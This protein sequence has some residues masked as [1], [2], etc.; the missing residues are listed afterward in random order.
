MPFVEVGDLSIHYEIAGRGEP[1]VLLHGM[2]NNSQSWRKQISELQ[3]HFTIIAWDAPGYGASSDPQYELRSF[4]QFADILKGFLEKL[5]YQSVNL[6]GHSMGAAI[7]IDFCHRYP[8]QVKSLIISDATR[9]AAAL[10]Q[11]ENEKRLKNRL[12]S[13]ETLDPQEIA[14]R[15][16][17]ELLAPQ[18]SDE[19]RREAER[20]MAQVRPAGYRSVAYSLYHV[21]QM[22]LL[23]AISI[24]TLVICGELD[25]VTPVSESRI[26]HESMPQSEFV[27]I[28]ETGHLCYQEDSATFNRHILNFL[29]GKHS[30][31]ERED[32]CAQ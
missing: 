26:F 22:D 24:P 4:C 18:A 28:P 14:K 11:E 19:V 15:R 9:G 25:K 31:R 29:S 16:V 20:I 6:L 8:S 13:I 21:N 7:A 17:K 10:D 1:L 5:P 32:V 23:S 12:N 2:G 27:I 30:D 3:E